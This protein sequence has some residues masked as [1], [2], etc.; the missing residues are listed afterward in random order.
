MNGA[1]RDRERVETDHVGS[2]EA[3]PSDRIYMRRIRELE[4]ENDHLQSYVK[5]L[6]SQLRAYQLQMPEFE[7]AHGLSAD[8]MRKSSMR[9][10]EDDFGDTKEE[11]DEGDGR[12][13]PPWV[14]GSDNFSPLLAAYDQ[15]IGYLENVLSKKKDV[16]SQIRN[17]TIGI[18]KENESLRERLRR[19]LEKC[20]DRVENGAVGEEGHLALLDR[21]SDRPATET[22]KARDEGVALLQHQLKNATETV[23]LLQQQTTLLENELDEARAQWTETCE[24][25]EAVSRNWHDTKKELERVSSEHASLTN[26]KR[27]LLE[28]V[29]RHTE[30]STEAEKKTP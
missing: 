27:V 12:P 20:A 7:A 19:S 8:T 11:R 13:L 23:D 15:R 30:R 29:K 4:G 24:Q 9:S 17:E 25:L 14:L 6:E 16:I 22:T 21:D 26:E 3:A 2:S 5:R 10:P 1:E 28:S 18:T